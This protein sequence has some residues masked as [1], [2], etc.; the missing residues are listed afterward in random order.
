[1]ELGTDHGILAV[2]VIK[3]HSV[4]VLCLYIHTY[5]HT[6]TV[7]LVITALIPGA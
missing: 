7:S 1:M 5:V 4:V 6:N 3:G 2:V